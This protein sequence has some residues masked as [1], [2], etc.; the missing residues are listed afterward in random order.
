MRTVLRSR[1]LHTLFVGVVFG[2][3][4]ADCAK[5]QTQSFPH[6]SVRLIAEHS[7]IEAAQAFTLGLHFSL[8]DNWHMYWVNPGDSGEPPRVTW[9]L[10]RG[11]T[12]GPIEWPAPEKLGT[13][14]IVDYGYAGDVTLLV[15]MR[16]AADFPS[17]EP[18]TV[19]ANV[20]LLVCKEMCI[21]AKTQL[22]LTLPGKAQTPPLDHAQSAVFA[23]AR[24]RLPH[25]P[26]ASWKFTAR[27][28]ADSFVLSAQV[29]RRVARAYFYP[30]EESQ[31]KNA[32]EQDITPDAAGFR[33]KLRKSNQLTKPVARLKGVL[34]LNGG[35]AYLV[36]AAVVPSGKAAVPKPA[37]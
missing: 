6:G 3:M 27:E 12:S 24:A 19:R 11:L 23:R 33:L 15:P 4:G 5:A 26:P 34:Q 35:R 17:Q 32:S 20:N 14:S 1:R 16:A 22:T 21:P 30:L 37:G 29:G 36:D 13:S 10:P 31:I 9:E 25:A 2:L 18:L 7:W 8:E 28:D